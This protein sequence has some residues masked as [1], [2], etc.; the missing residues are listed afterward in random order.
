M[1][2]R[3]CVHSPAGGA[4]AALVPDAAVDAGGHLVFFRLMPL[5]TA[6]Y[7]HWTACTGGWAGELE[8]EGSSGTPAT[9][10]AGA[11]DGRAR[12]AQHGGRGGADRRRLLAGAV[13]ALH[14]LCRQ[15]G[16]A[17][18]G[19]MHAIWLPAPWEHPWRS[20]STLVP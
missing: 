1:G 5:D 2:G 13:H 10:A 12:G 11:A 3:G 16:A 15:E 7:T 14:A 9:L 19:A 4:G 20:A 6:L 18:R 17:P 8:S